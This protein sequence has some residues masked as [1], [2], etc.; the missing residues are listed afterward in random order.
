MANRIRLRR[1]PLLTL[2]SVFAA[3]L[4]VLGSTVAA[5]GPANAAVDNITRIVTPDGLMIE[6]ELSDT[7]LSFVR[8]LDGNP[9]T[10]EWFQHGVL[11]YR[12]KGPGADKFTGKVTM[13]YQ[14][15]FPFS[16]GTISLSYSNPELGTRTD[17]PSGTATFGV[18]L[19]P[20]IT[21][22]KV[23]TV[24]VTGPS[25][26]FKVWGWHVSVTGVIGR[27]SVR[28]YFRVTS[29]HGDSVTAYGKIWSH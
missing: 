4:A 29:T 20:G 10:R 22:A 21:D 3:T 26:R 6:A 19:G 17:I 1:T 13:G 2:V 23:G 12:V 28:P 5:T 11:A 18:G 14:V 16:T 15:G 27:T 24:D 9:S 8:P 25:G 7:R